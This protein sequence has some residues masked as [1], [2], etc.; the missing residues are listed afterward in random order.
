MT[1]C[2]SSLINGL[3]LLQ[4]L[5]FGVIKFIYLWSRNNDN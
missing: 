3:D 1:N 5:L 4:Y 2:E